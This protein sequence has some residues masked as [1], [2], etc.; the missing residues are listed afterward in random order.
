MG[1]EKE[2]A[3]KREGEEGKEENAK[4]GGKG[5]ITVKERRRKGCKKGGE[6]S[7]MQVSGAFV[8]KLQGALRSGGVI[9]K[10]EQTHT[11]THCHPVTY[12]EINNISV[13]EKETGRTDH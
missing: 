11:H 13:K 7:K 3:G 9:E 6:V 10:T 12:V 2:V 5:E 4:E 1:K 8:V